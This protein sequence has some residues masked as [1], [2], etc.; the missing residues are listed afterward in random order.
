LLGGIASANRAAP[1]Q[2]V[3]VVPLIQ[4]QRDGRMNDAAEGIQF[5]A[6]FDNAPYAMVMVDPRGEIVLINSQTEGLVG[7]PVQ[8]SSARPRKS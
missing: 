5:P 8:N 3:A 4:Q 6:F 7:F 2:E 1:Y